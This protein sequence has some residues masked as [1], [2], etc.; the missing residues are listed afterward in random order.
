MKSTIKVAYSQRVGK[1]GFYLGIA[2]LALL[3][4]HRDVALHLIYYDDD[5]EDLPRMKSLT[6][7]LSELLPDS[8]DLAPDALMNPPK[9]SRQWCVAACRG[10]YVRADFRA[11]NHFVPLFQQEAMGED[12]WM[13]VAGGALKRVDK[14]INQCQ[15]QAG[16]FDDEDMVSSM[17]DH[18]GRLQN[19]RDFINTMH[20]SG[21]H[22]VLVPG[23]GDCGL[24]TLLNLE[25]GVVSGSQLCPRSAVDDMRRE[26]HQ[27]KILQNQFFSG[28]LL[29]NAF[30]D[31]S[32][33]NCLKSASKY[34]M[35][36]IGKFK[37]RSFIILFYLL[38]AF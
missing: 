6:D 32:V 11:L 3:V 19:K 25:G 23:D 36:T 7:I 20:Q 31:L 28:F 12:L 27:N 38:V 22:P 16:E 35:L 1:R 8:M 29:Q 10:D 26:T 15:S 21:V 4:A 37:F 33:W 13:N 2:D 5:F 18:V 14:Q 17:M 24:W 9:S 34:W 30:I